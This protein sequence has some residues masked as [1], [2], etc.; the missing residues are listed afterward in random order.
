MTSYAGIFAFTHRA[1][2]KTILTL[3][4]SLLTA[5]LLHS[6]ATAQA[7]VLYSFDDT[8]G[9]IYEP[10]TA[11][12]A[13]AAGNFYGNAGSGGVGDGFGGIF[14]LTPPATKGGHW[15]ESTL[16]EFTN[17]ADGGYDG[18]CVIYGGLILDASGDLYG[19]TPAGGTGSGVVFELSPP[20]VSGGS[21][22]ETVLYTFTNGSDA[23]PRQL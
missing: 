9:L 18:C 13:D 3:A 14:K 16:Y 4:A 7:T 23:V 12:V 6:T 20:S 22:T 17:G 11:L 15:A 19:T 1:S 21:W 5:A 8:A 10:Q 2:R